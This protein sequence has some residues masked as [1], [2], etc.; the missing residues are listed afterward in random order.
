M[1]PLHSN[2]LTTRMM[3]T[4]LGACGQPQTGLP[5]LGEAFPKAA[6]ALAMLGGAFSPIRVSVSG[7]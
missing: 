3:Q 2:I 4:V 6:G 1:Q 5:T 7:P